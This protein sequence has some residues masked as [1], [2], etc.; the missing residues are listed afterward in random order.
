M[1]AT[2]VGK[3]SIF[4][5]SSIWSVLPGSGIAI[6]LVRVPPL[7]HQAMPPGSSP[8]EG[9]R[10]LAIIQEAAPRR[11]ISTHHLH[12]SPWHGSPAGRGA[13]AVA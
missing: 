12:R 2:A 11:R 10:T 9:C 5:Q 13:S 4:S 3:T 6:P 1:V 8:L 7:P